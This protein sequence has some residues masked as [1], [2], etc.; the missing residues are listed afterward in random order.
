MTFYAAAK[1]YVAVLMPND[2]VAVCRLLVF[3]GITD[4]QKR[5]TADGEVFS[6]NLRTE[7]WEHLTKHSS[8]PKPHGIAER[9]HVW[10]NN[11]KPLPFQPLS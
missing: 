3:G 5:E 4:L 6:F 9:I 8:D 11:V 10:E 2:A 7:E 1:P